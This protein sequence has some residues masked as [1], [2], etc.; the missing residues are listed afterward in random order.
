MKRLPPSVFGKEIWTQIEFIF[1]QH[2]LD[3]LPSRAACDGLDPI[4]V[5]STKR[6]IEIR[7]GIWFLPGGRGSP[8]PRFHLNLTLAH[9]RFSSFE[10]VTVEKLENTT[11]SRSS[12]D[13]GLLSV[14]IL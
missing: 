13:D 4:E 12:L 6:G 2:E 5:E 14:V 1:R 9:P 3:C 11:I 8:N 7:G 10:S